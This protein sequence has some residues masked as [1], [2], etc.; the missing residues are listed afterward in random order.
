LS[1][2]NILGL[3]SRVRIAHIARYGIIFTQ[4]LCQSRLCKADHACLTYLMLQRQLSHLNGR[5][6]YVRQSQSYFTTGG[7]PPIVRLE[8]DPLEYHDQI[9]FF[10]FATEP[11][12][13]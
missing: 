3:S 6:I 8:T 1:L 11:F 4:V 13:S 10:F 9:F 5:K 7:L 12:R 2:M